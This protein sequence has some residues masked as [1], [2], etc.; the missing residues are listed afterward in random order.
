MAADGLETEAPRSAG[1]VVVALAAIAL[2]SAGWAWWGRTAAGA[3]AFLLAGLGLA[4]IFSGALTIAG[5]LRAGALDWGAP[6]RRSVALA[7]WLSAGLTAAHF[8]ALAG[9]RRDFDGAFAQARSAV[10]AVEAHRKRTGTLPAT[11]AEAD[12]AAGALT[13][14]PEPEGAYLLCFESAGRQRSCYRSRTRQW[15][16]RP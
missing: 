5:L 2:I 4:V 13:F 3:A 1:R 16:L 9:R 12:V 8:V 15:E 10:E 7:L 11:L 14:E 6:V